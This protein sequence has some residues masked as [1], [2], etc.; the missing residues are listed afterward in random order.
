V[1]DEQLCIPRR[2][3]DQVAAVSGRVREQRLDAGHR[4]DDVG[5]EITLD[6]RSPASPGS[7]SPS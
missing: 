5:N 6:P 2:C 3:L 4:T 1:G 7:T